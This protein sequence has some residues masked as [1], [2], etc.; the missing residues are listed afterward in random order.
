M[1]LR[2]RVAKAGPA[3]IQELG[4]EANL[5]GQQQ[6]GTTRLE[7]LGCRLEID[8]RFAGSGDAPQQES[9]A[10]L[11]LLNRGE[12]P[13]LIRRERFRE[14][15]L[16]SVD[17]CRGRCAVKEA[18]IAPDG[19]P[20]QQGVADGSADLRGLEG[21]ALPALTS[22][23][24]EDLQQTGLSLAPAGELLLRGRLDQLEP[25][26][27]PGAFRGGAG[28]L[29][30]PAGRQDRLQCSK[31]GGAAL[32]RNRLNQALPMRFNRGLL[33][34]RFNRLQGFAGQG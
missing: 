9:A 16:G 15:V 2:H 22:L 26:L 18:P 10:G 3:A 28:P 7:G 24:L 29:S 13:G 12:G 23:L 6:H 33:V 25:Q 1:V 5:G 21:L 30:Q 20:A 11:R 8:L 14:G 34:D 31:G 19:S 32:L 17:G 4:D 27:L